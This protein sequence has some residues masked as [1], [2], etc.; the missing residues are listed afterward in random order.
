MKKL[1]MLLALALVLPTMFLTVG[2]S[3]ADDDDATADDD[4]TSNDDDATDDDDDA[5]DDDDAAPTYSISGTISPP[6][7][8]L[9]VT[10]CSGDTCMFSPTDGTGNFSCG[11]ISDGVWIVH[12]IG[13]P[14]AATDPNA[15]LNW[16]SFYDVVT[17]SGADVALGTL[18]IP[19]ITDT[20]EA[21]ADSGTHTF[22]NDVVVEWDAP[23]DP[24][25]T[26][27]AVDTLTLGCA[28]IPASDYAASTSGVV[29][30]FVF[31]P[32]EMGIETGEFRVTV[33]VDGI[34][35]ADTVSAVFAHYESDIFSGEWSNADAVAGEGT[36]T[37][38]VELLSALYII[39]E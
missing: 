1:L 33:P 36:V 25:L 22:D 4:D 26:A 24:P 11:N 29:A 32:F 10:C 30:G 17:V 9:T 35:P 39:Q 15:P 8:G 5:T 19:E 18:T 14:G 37:V 34:T 13:I 3:H 23:F 31:A 21:T 12:N 38:D 16:A 28:T 20:F 7:E 27:V 6:E 2:C